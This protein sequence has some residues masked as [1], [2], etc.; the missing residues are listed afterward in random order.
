MTT[1]CSIAGSNTSR[2]PE[3]ASVH[4]TQAALHDTAHAPK[5]QA[6]RD[7]L[8][9]CGIGVEP[10]KLSTGGAR[11]R[12]NASCHASTQLHSGVLRG[13]FVMSTGPLHIGTG[14]H[15]HT[16]PHAALTRPITLNCFPSACR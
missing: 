9:E 4:A 1:L 14:E 8:A 7:L 13:S 16:G 5:L 15:D 6:L 2:R 12:R 10:G 3:S 11:I